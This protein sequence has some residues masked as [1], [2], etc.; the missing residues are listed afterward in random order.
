MNFRDLAKRATALLGF[1]TMLFGGSQSALG[2]YV[3]QPNGSPVVVTGSITAGDATMSGRINRDGVPSSCTGGAPTAAPISGTFSYD[4]YNYT[5]PTGQDVCVTV[6]YDM[7]QCGGTTNNS[8][9]VD[10]Y[11][12]FN[13]AS[14]NTNV[15]GKPGFSTVGTG[16][17]SFRVA[18]GASFVIVVHGVASA[19]TGVCSSYTYKLTYRTGC[20]EAGYDHTNDG[21]ADPTFF[22]SS[23]TTWNVLNSAGGT[24]SLLFGLSN[25]IITAGDYTGDGRTDVSTYRPTTGQWFY[26]TSQTSP[27][28]NVTYQPWGMNGDIA[29]PGDYDKDGK[30]DVAV[31]R[32]SDATVYIL[33]SSTN[34]ML[35]GQ[36]GANGD[37]PVTGD[38]DGD[39]SSDLAVVRNVG[40]TYRWFIRN[41]NFGYGFE[42]G[43]GTSTPIC[44]MGVPFGSSTDR[45]VS[46]DFDGD[47]RSDI[48]VYRP[49]T[50]FWYYLASSL[51]VQNAPG[52]TAVRSFQWGLN[53]DI[54]QP[55]DYD[56]DKMTD[57]AVFRPSTGVW[58]LSNSG[59]G[60]YSTYSSPTWGTATDQPATAAYRQTNP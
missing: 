51:N 26:S 47:A 7:T 16:T 3:C 37:V 45:I 39:L 18:A 27:Q 9:Q 53:G 46:G 60:A 33:L 56:G 23:D 14:T 15:I 1:V 42:Y 28:T 2:Q 50:G 48:A 4:A 36:W 12:S 49:S 52:A 24:N 43:C 30:S 59:G 6:E 34:T 21:K 29:I 11:S 58:Y 32:P 25:D 54:P 19:G 44:A 31:W 38:F 13:P 40:G 55:A 20:R 5:N 10:A 8:T 22:R 57:F 17:L 35:Y 41:S